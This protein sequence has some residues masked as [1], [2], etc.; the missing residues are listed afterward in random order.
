MNT[1]KQIVAVVVPP[2]SV[3]G[4]PRRLVEFADGSG[5]VQSWRR[6][7]GAGRMLGQGR[8]DGLAH[9]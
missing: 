2:C 4:V 7:L 1:E 3:D 6:A 9:L 5:A 8:A